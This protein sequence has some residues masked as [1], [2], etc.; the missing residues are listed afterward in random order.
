M[1]VQNISSGVMPVASQSRSGSQM[2]DLLKDYPELKIGGSGA[3][4]KYNV[5]VHP[6]I[7]NAM[8]TDPELAG[9]VHQMLA[10]TK[11]DHDN[12][13]RTLNAAGHQLIGCSTE[14]REDGSVW[15]SVTGSCESGSASGKGKTM[16]EALE[17]MLE[18]SKEKEEEAERLEKKKMQEKQLK[19]Q[20]GVSLAISA[21]QNG[22]QESMEKRIDMEV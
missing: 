1:N 10:N 18:K 15:C 5:S 8:E 20:L 14:M 12:L 2:K 11:S 22:E 21:T 19:G 16:Q 4:G 6:A 3:R 9:R 17:E 13:E 7:L